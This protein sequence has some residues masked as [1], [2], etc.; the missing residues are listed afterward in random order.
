MSK[1]TDQDKGLEPDEIVERV[2]PDPTKPGARR[3]VGLFLGKSS[4]DDY[5]RL[6]MNEGFSHFL[7]FRK[8]DTLDAQRAASGRLVVWLQP[9][10]KV[11]ETRTQ[12]GPVE[13][14]HGTIL[15]GNLGAIRDAALGGGGPRMALDAAGCSAASCFTSSGPNCPPPNYPSVG[16]TCGCDG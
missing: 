13:F 9:T 7:E 3:L 16:Y 2:V 5:W 12:T 11:R 8:E 4:D 15:K 1:K 10:S 6:Y 14:V